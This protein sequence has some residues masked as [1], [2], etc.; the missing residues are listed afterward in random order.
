[1]KSRASLVLM[2]QLIMILVFALAAALCLQTFVKADHI[3]RET[4]M[5]DQ[6][7][8][9]TQNGA[10]TLKACEGD[11]AAAARLLGGV[12]S[13]DRL[14]VDHREMRLELEITP[15]EI[16]GLGRAEVRVVGTETE[17]TLFSLT[18]S[19]QEVD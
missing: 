5:Q 13:G 1:M 14:T 18:V 10:E 17:E 19:W 9:L 2:E 6:A 8:I 16:P 7:V 12:P 11:L 4:A 15:S 3:S